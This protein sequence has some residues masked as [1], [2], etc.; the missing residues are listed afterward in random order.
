M[1]G[2]LERQRRRATTE[3]LY[4]RG[5]WANS[6]IHGAELAT[7]AVKNLSVDFETWVRDASLVKR[8]ENYL[9]QLGIQGNMVQFSAVGMGAGLWRVGTSS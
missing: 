6:Q 7:I 9:L 4:P 8:L 3:P 2:C 5:R 1:A